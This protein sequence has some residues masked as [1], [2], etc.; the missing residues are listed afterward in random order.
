MSGFSDRKAVETNSHNSGG[1]E[2][3]LAETAWLGRLATQL[4][5][6]ADRDDLVQDVLLSA[7]RSGGRRG[8]LRAWLATVAR[9]LAARRRTRDRNRRAR[10]Q[11]V[12]RLESGEP[13]FGLFLTAE[14]AGAAG[15]PPHVPL[16]APGLESQR[17][18]AI[19]RRGSDD[20]HGCP[21]LQ[22]DVQDGRLIAGFDVAHDAG[23]SRCG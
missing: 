23:V 2:A 13:S 6:E 22:I 11:R 10:E 16:L 12:G 7:M 20:P 3:L 14:R 1:Y 18:L 17:E 4:V 9:N 19:R 15:D 5:P 8:H 21:L